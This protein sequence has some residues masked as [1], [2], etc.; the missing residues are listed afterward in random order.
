VPGI[1]VNASKLKQA[2]ERP[3]GKADDGTYV[4]ELA[5]CV[6]GMKVLYNSSLKERKYTSKPADEGAEERTPRKP[7]NPD[8]LKEIVSMFF[9]QYL[10]FG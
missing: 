2:E 4:K 9:S 8:V 10:L 5:V 6:F 3:L 7:L 1:F